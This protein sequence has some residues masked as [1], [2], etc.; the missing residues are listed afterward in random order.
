MCLKSGIIGIE[1]EQDNIA[2]LLFLPRTQMSSYPL[3]WFD[4]GPDL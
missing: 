1:I 3:H 2:G 4:D